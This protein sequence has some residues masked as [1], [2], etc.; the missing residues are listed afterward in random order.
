MVGGPCAA[1]FSIKFH[2]TCDLGDATVCSNIWTPNPLS[3]TAHS[4]S[5][6]LQTVASSCM[7]MF[8]DAAL[9]YT[10]CCGVC[11][12]PV[13]LISFQY[14]RMSVFDLMAGMGCCALWWVYLAL[15]QVASEF[16]SSG[17]SISIWCGRSSK[18][19]MGSSPWIPDTRTP[20]CTECLPISRK[21]SQSPE[22]NKVLPNH[23]APPPLMIFLCVT[24][25]SLASIQWNW[26]WKLVT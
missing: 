14:I 12:S 9:P 8:S 21:V 23:G 16:A 18:L 15:E 3:H 17:Q 24:Q 1:P 26:N 13:L 10:Q 4:W 6:G 20:C 19:M 22:C 5:A 11:I 2:W 25:N 7:R